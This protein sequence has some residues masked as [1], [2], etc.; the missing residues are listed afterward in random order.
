MARESGDSGAM[1]CADA[2][3]PILLSLSF[4]LP[5]NFEAPENIDS[6]ISAATISGSD[7]ISFTG[8]K[9]S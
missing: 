2:Q 9:S 4:N 1:L 6:C 3:L 8:G 7:G 5:N